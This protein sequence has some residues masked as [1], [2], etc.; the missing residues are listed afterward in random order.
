V[1][2]GAAGRAPV[3]GLVGRNLLSGI[4]RSSGKITRALGGRLRTALAQSVGAGW[5]AA[6]TLSIQIRHIPF[7]GRCASGTLAGGRD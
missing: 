1:L 2:P 7:G 6:G 4:G 5:R 3:S